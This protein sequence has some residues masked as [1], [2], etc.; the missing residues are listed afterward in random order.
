LH[1]E[2]HD[3]DSLQKYIE[4]TT[5][6]KNDY[7]S[8]LQG[9]SDN[10]MTGTTSVPLILMNHCQHSPMSMYKSVETGFM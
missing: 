7:I 8:K 10:I 9:C 2:F 6:N 4:K 5:K 1:Y 3:V